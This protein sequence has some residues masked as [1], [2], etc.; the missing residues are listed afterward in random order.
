MANGLNHVSLIEGKGSLQALK[1]LLSLCD[2]SGPATLQLAAVN[3]QII[4]GIK[5]VRA[6]P[7]MHRVRS[8]PAKAGMCRGMEVHVEFDEEKYS[9]TGV[10]L[11]ASVLERFF[12][13][14]TGVNSFTKMSAK[15]CQAEGYLKSWPPRAGA[16]PLP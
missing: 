5:T 3:Q 12:A 16:N 4:D 14:Y 2:F 8:S 15:T 9:G 13:L 7:I 11:V 10:F 6:Q 1:E